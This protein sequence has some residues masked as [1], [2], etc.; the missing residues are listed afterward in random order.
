MYYWLASWLAGLI[1]MMKYQTPPS[2]RATLNE[3]K[4]RLCGGL[5]TPDY[6]FD[7]MIVLVQ[8]W[9]KG[10]H[11]PS[12]QGRRYAITFGKKKKLHPLTMIC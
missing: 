6:C 2:A 1:D 3:K 11:H 4:K 5:L 10:N 12:R 8:T 9:R 7:P